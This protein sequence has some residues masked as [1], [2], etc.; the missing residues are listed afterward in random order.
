ML[1]L[2]LVQSLLVKDPLQQLLL[3]DGRLRPLA[4]ADRLLK[5]AAAMDPAP[6]ETAPKAKRAY[7]RKAKVSA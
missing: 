6:A 1:F 3:T 2:L 5:E 4:E 7:N